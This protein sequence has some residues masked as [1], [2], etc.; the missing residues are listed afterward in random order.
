[1]MN[2]GIY[3]FIAGIVFSGIGGM[4]FRFRAITNKPA[5]GGLTSPFMILGIIALVIGGAIVVF[6]GK[7]SGLFN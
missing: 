2:I 5:W 7:S 1:M 3:I 4:S 6:A